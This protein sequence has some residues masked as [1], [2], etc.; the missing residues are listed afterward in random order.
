MGHPA[1]HSGGLVQPAGPAIPLHVYPP[2][3]GGSFCYRI[4]DLFSRFCF[5]F[6]KQEYSEG[7][8]SVLETTG[9]AGNKV[10]C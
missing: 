9:I 7:L 2:G 10:A 3:S 8:W 4:Q 6:L 1:H 5:P